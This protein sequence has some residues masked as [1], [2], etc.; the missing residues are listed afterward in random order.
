[1][2]ELPL[3]HLVLVDVHTGKSWHYDAGKIHLQISAPNIRGSQE[4]IFLFVSYFQS[5]LGILEIGTVMVSQ[6]D[7]SI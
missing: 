1:M 6:S 2:I 4:C 5:F 3:D 7:F